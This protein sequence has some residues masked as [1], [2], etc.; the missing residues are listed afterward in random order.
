MRS[1]ASRRSS[2]RGS[3]AVMVCG[4]AWKRAI[5][6]RTKWQLSFKYEYQS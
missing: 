3:A 2:G 4:P 6:Y 1:M 5:T